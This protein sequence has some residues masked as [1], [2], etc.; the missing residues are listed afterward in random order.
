MPATAGGSTSGSSTSVTTSDRPRKRRVAR[1]NAVGV[2]SPMIRRF[3]T[4]FVRAVTRSAS[5]TVWS[6][7][8]AGHVAQRHLGE[9]R[10]DRH[11]EE[12]QRHADAQR[13]QDGQAEPPGARS[14]PR[15]AAGR[16]RQLARGRRCVEI[17][18]VL[19]VPQLGGRPKPAA[20]SRPRPRVRAHLRD[21]RGR[22][23]GVGAAA[24][25]PADLVADRRLGVAR[26]P[27]ACR[28]D[29]RRSCRR[30]RTRSRRPPSRAR[31]S[32]RCSRRSA[33]S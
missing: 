8:Q 6:P 33:P 7:Q 9:Q 29:P 30:S 15:R 2:P 18:D 10:D 28:C 16:R 24:L 22:T 32:T 21:E 14:R 3:A 27:D 4:R 1:T 31:P 20:F 17:S 12:R 13:E 5:C 19:S 23:A 26:Q 25:D 11:R